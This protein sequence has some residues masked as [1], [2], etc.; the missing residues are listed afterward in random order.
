MKVN[1][2]TQFGTALVSRPAGREAF[3]A[4]DANVLCRLPPTERI[5]ID[6]SELDVLTPSWGE[7]FFTALRSAYGGRVDLLPSDNQ[8]VK[9]TLETI[10]QSAKNG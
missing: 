7:E 9:L 2:V 5:E 3:A 4:L 8:S 1:I 6:F 10:G